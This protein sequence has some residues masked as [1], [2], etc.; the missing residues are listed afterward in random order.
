[1]EDPQGE[2]PTLV[3]QSN[4]KVVPV[5]Q[6]Y[7]FTKYLGYLNLEFNEQG[8]LIKFSGEPIL[9]D[10][11]VPQDEE[12]LKLLKK[13]RHESTD[14]KILGYT[15]VNL[16]GTCVRQ[17]CNLG[18]FYAD[19]IVDWRESS[20]VFTEGWTDASIA[21]VTGGDI[22]ASFNHESETEHGE[23]EREDVKLI[24]PFVK[25]I[26]MVEITG[27]V[28]K[29]MLEHSVE[30]STTYSRPGEFLQFS[31]VKIVYDLTH[32]VG[33]RVKDVKIRCSKCN[34]KV[35]EDLD[36]SKTYKILLSD[37]LA[38][39]G[40]GYVML[41]DKPMEVFNKT[42]PDIL[43]EYIKKMSPIAPLVENR[44]IIIGKSL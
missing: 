12:I 10:G 32:P 22:R 23:I 8:E 29:D 20:N 27:K 18:N 35:Y 1:M 41:V 14:S 7:A 15:K 11:S 9:L 4:G 42:T 19:A 16:D 3:T 21:L 38:K 6:V 39:G 25:N 31:G 34:D 28:F 30:R 26:T 33:D 37:Y 40:D 24:L 17:E 43:M 36:Y 44:I 5:V 2:Y 13:Y